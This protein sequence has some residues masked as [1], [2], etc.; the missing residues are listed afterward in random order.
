MNGVHFNY[1]DAAPYV[2]Y[3]R[4]ER[5]IKT[6]TRGLWQQRKGLKLH[7]KWNSKEGVHRKKHVN[8]KSEAAEETGQ[9]KETH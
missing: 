7:A 3:C 4:K 1:T 9:I 8:M 5:E 6:G 2:A